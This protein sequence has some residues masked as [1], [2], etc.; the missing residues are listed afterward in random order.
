MEYR[1]GGSYKVPGG[2][3]FHRL[4]GVCE[5]LQS[6]RK[7]STMVSMAVLPCD[8]G[9]PVTKSGEMCDK[10]QLGTGSGHDK[11]AGG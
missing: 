2:Q 3:F 4:L 1:G 8:G 7:R 10:G 11:P 6:E 9:K 5:E